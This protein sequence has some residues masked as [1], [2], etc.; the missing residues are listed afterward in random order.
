MKKIIKIEYAPEQ[1]TLKRKRVAAYCRVSSSFDDQLISLDAQKQ[2]YVDFISSNP[3]WEFA[4]IYYDEG[5]TST[6][7][8]IRP[9]LMKMILDCEAGKIDLILT[10]SLSR[11]ARNTTDCL[12]LVRK[13]Q[14][15]GIPIY[16]EKE[17]LNT[18][19]IES[20][21]LLSVMSSLA[22]SESA[23]NSAN[24]RWSIRHRFENGTYK[25]GSAPYGYSIEDGQY[26]IR[27]DEAQWVRFMFDSFVKGLSS[28]QVAQMLTEKKVP[29][30]RGG[31]WQS[32]TVCAILKNERYIGD[33]LLQKTYKDF[34][35]KRN[36]NNKG[37]RDQFY[38]KEHHEPIISR[39][40]FEAAQFALKHR[41]KE[42]NLNVG[43]LNI[44]Y[45]FT[46]KIVC[47]ECGSLFIRRVNSCG[48]RK[49]YVWVCREHLRHKE[50]CS[51]KFVK[52]AALEV[53][54]VTMMNKLIFARKKVLLGLLDGI[55]SQN[56]RVG[57][58]KINEIDKSIRKLSERRQSLTLMATRGIIDS[59]TFIQ[60]TN[61]INA[62]QEELKR[63][64]EQIINGENDM[65]QKTKYLEDLISFTEK[66][67]MYTEFDKGLFDR[68]VNRITLASRTT[69]VFHLKCGLNLKEVIQ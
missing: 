62:E 65:S 4:G 7:K 36:R 8:E 48:N 59:A 5:I 10:K 6:R 63:K 14:N 21:L 23:S 42:K 54:F 68:F 44:H 20:E 41:I 47:G 69:A 61:S 50:K 19:T 30:R 60:E 52:E 38:V 35:S 55:R 58:K 51:M 13:L 64:K 67:N 2:H 34:L 29:T 16:F 56:N 43:K 66:K 18:E 3:G 26:V 1:K 57:M 12:E 9:A 22:Q 32:T 24:I 31:K 46:G 49:Y 33:C 37:E 15:L 39:E 53:A 11:F 28:H 45:P 40:Y 25:P 27:E 17:N